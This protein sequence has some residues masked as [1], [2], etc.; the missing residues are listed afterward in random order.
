MKKVIKLL[1][2]VILIIVLLYI[3][4]CIRNFVI[5]NG[6]KEKISKLKTLEVFEETTK[7]DNEEP[8]IITKNKNIVK[9]EDNSDF[10]KYFNTNTNEM[11]EE[12]LKTGERVLY[13]NRLCSINLVLLETEDTFWKKVF[14]NIIT[15]TKINEEKCYKINSRE[16]EDFT[17][18]V[19]ADTGLTMKASTK[20]DRTVEN[21]EYDYKLDGIEE[22]KFEKENITE[23]YVERPDLD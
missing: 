10:V 9:L 15:T 17:Y 12:N 19:S 22:L 4:N 5:L 23:K 8:K 20:Y 1:M 21:I 18:Y 7:M 13:Q 11:I 3:I 14:S 6:L 16:Y 2:T